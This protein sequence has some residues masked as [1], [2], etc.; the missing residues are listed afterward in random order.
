MA[1]SWSLMP[2][3]SICDAKSDICT[4]ASTL[5]NSFLPMRPAID[6]SKLMKSVIKLMVANQF[7]VSVQ[8]SE[9]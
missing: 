5:R 3:I 2:S 8:G 6:F 7:N 9:E 1:S 4:N